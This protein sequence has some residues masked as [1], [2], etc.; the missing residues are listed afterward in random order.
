MMGQDVFYVKDKVKNGK[1]DI[2]VLLIFECLV[3]NLMGVV[4]NMFVFFNLNYLRDMENWIVEYINYS[5]LKMF[6]NVKEGLV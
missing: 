4:K 6:N 2:V 5:S 1:E 3:L